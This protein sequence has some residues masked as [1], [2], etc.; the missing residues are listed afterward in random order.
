MK[1]GDSFDSA[2]EVHNLRHIQWRLNFADIL[3]SL[4]PSG[5][6]HRNVLNTQKSYKMLTLWSMEY[7]MHSNSLAYLLHS[8]S[9]SC[10]DSAMYG[11]TTACVLRLVSKTVNRH[12]AMNC[13][14]VF[15]YD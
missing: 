5:K 3:T 15:I 13:E 4:Q 14:V 10:D 8:Y 7:T 9:G 1:E 11:W 2:V 6:C 12:N